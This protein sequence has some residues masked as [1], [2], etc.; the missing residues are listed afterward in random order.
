MS[1]LDF[2]IKDF[3]IATIYDKLQRIDLGVSKSTNINTI[4]KNGEAFGIKQL[5]LFTFVLCGVVP[6]PPTGASPLDPT[7][8]FSVLR[9]PLSWSPKNPEMACITRICILAVDNNL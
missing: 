5:S 9:T 2:I 4:I 8:E 6:R 7:E 3:T 1:S